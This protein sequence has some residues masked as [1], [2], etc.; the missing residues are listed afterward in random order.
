MTPVIQ[1]VTERGG[2]IERFGFR[3]LVLAPADGGR[4]VRYAKYWLA[5]RARNSASRAATIDRHANDADSIARQAAPHFGGIYGNA[6]TVGAARTDG[7]I[8]RHRTWPCDRGAQ[9]SADDSVL[10]SGGNRIGLLRTRP[11]GTYGNEDDDYYECSFVHPED[12]L[13]RAA[14]LAIHQQSSISIR[15]Y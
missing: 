1:L 6:R 15:A 3:G 8:T 13:V 14:Q 10:N 12:F 5:S 9:S 7:R 11:C 4:Q 2:Q